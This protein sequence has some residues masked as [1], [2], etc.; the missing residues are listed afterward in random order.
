MRHAHARLD[1]PASG[2]RR[3]LTLAAAAVALP[4]CALNS[5][6]DA[7]ELAETELAHAPFPAAYRAGGMNGVVAKPISAP[8][9]LAEIARATRPANDELAVA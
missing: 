3:L 4:G 1:S 9:L 2:R 7:K 8:T 5:P 6:P